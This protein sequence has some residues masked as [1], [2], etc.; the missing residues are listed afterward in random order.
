MLKTNEIYQGDCLEL[1]KQI[2]IPD[3]SID[4]ILTDPPYGITNCAWDKRIPFEPM[5]AEVMRVAKDNAAIAMFAKGKF[6]IELA[7]SNL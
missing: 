2:P 5:W 6:L 1:L 4:L 3:A 7:N